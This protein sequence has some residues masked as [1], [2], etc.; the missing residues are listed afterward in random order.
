MAHLAIS[1]GRGEGLEALEAWLARRIAD[2]LSG[3]DFPAVTRER[4]RIRLERARDHLAAAGSAMAM[5]PEVAAEDVRQ[6][7]NALAEIVGEVGVEDVLGE[8]FASFCI[9]K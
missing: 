7:A 5:G 4:H 2:D 1:A 8:V 9:G 3:A 6:S